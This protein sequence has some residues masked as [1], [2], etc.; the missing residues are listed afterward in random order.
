MKRLLS[1]IA[2][3]AVTS[4]VLPAQDS[5]TG[6]FAAGPGPVFQ[7]SHGG[8][9][10][11]AYRGTLSANGAPLPTSQYNGFD[12]W[13]V[14]ANGIYGGGEVT[15]RRMSSLDV[16]PLRS[17]LAQAAYLTTLRGTHT[18]GAQMSALHG[19]IWSVTGGL[20]A[21][22]NPQ[23]TPAMD[24]L[25]DEARANYAS[26]NL[27][28]FYYIEFAGDPSRQ[29]ELIF[30]GEGSPFTVPEPTGVALLGMAGAVLVI[31]RLRRRC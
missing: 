1:T 19:A 23:S 15:V 30:Q 27:E 14:D 18:T 28:N 29:Q 24:A 10:V 16:G 2:L 3:L 8:L 26:V 20:P 11:G 7:Y 4:S 21:R 12:F 22:W 9:G 5:W 25:I 13:C 31:G 17:S 6:T